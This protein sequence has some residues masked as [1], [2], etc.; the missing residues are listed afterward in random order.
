MSRRNFDTG[1]AD[2]AKFAALISRP[3]AST[4]LKRLPPLSSHS[5]VLDLACGN[6]AATAAIVEEALSRGNDPPPTILGLDIAP[7]MVDLYQQMANSNSWAT[8]SSRVQ[9]AQNLQGVP[10]DEFDLVFMNFGIMFTPEASECTKEIYRVLKPGGYAVLTTW[11]DAG[12]P[13]LLKRTAAS[14]GA[15]QTLAPTDNGWD[16]KERLHSTVQE[17]GFEEG[18][19]EI[20]VVPSKWEAGSADGIAQALSAPFWNSLHDGTPEA[21]SR[22][23]KAVRENLTPQQE[24]TA[25]IDMIAWLCLAKKN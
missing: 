25:S 22:W 23:Q 24:E 2:Y 5:R 19:I 18:N 9:D 6:G 13:Q 16:T 4:A 8:V 1:A 17:G 11:K 10:D 7:G 12:I 14:V 3:I 15:P 20:D 21:T